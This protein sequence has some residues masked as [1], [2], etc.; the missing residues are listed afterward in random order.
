MMNTSQSTAAAMSAMVASRR[1]RCSEGGGS[2]VAEVFNGSSTC[3]RLSF[4][5]NRG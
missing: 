4:D 3:V 2:E 5:G 1:L